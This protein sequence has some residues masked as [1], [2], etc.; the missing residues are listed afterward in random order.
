MRVTWV[1]LTVAYSLLSAASSDDCRE[2]DDHFCVLANVTVVL[3]AEV[4]VQCDFAF[5][6]KFQVAPKVLTGTFS[7]V[8]L[9]EALRIFSNATH[10]K[11][12]LM[13]VQKM[14]YDPLEVISLSNLANKAADMKVG[15]Y[16]VLYQ[17]KPTITYFFE[18]FVATTSDFVF[19]IDYRTPKEYVLGNLTDKLCKTY[20]NL[21]IPKPEQDVVL[22]RQNLTSAWSVRKMIIGTLVPMVF[23]SF[24]LLIAVVCR[25]RYFL[26]RFAFNQT[27][28]SELPTLRPDAKA[29]ANVVVVSATDPVE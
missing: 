11:A 10:E 20:P 5:L 24:F 8:L 17:P 18:T 13:Y 7:P 23:V 26:G 3:V 29:K 2:S 28:H 21:E 25:K 16:T 27:N 6:P 19:D 14:E 15:V 9:T 1:A 22:V 12:L 4:A